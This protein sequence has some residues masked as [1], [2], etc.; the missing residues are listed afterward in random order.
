MQQIPKFR[1][2]RTAKL[3][4]CRTAKLITLSLVITAALILS[5][6]ST[7]R[8]TYLREIGYPPDTTYNKLKT[9]YRLQPADI[10]YVRIITQDEDVNQLY[11]PM[12]SQGGGSTMLQGEGLYIMGYEVRDSG[13]VELP[14]LKKIHVQGLT[15]DEARARLISVAE[16]HLRDPQVIVK[17]HTF[18]ISVLGEVNT[19]GQ[20]SYSTY[21]MN[22]L[23]ALALAGDITYNG[24]R[25]NIV[26]MRPN[27]DKYEVY[28]ID[29][30]DKEL[31]GTPA[32]FVQPND[33]IYVEPLRST[34]FRETTS[35]Y[36]FFV[37]AIT[38]VLSLVVLV[39]GLL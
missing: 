9:A 11:N 25:E 28:R 34:L 24:N 39:I 19:P 23:E 4:N 10:L 14:I 5:S 16:T 37:S 7:K 36:M 17:M 30:T 2:T 18:E 15:L 32:F 26:L 22:L 35:D 13:Y 20:L 27:Q 21:E 31:V 29:L 12:L 1:Q 6:C 8:L 38:G 33:I 3:Q